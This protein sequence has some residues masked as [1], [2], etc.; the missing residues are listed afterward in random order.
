MLA[1]RWCAII[2][3]LAAGLTL[4]GCGAV[5]LAYNNAPDLTYW[6]LDGFL[7]LDSAQ[8]ARLRNDLNALQAWHRKEELP[9]VAEMLKNLQAAVSP[10]RGCRS[11]MPAIALP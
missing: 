6:W 2:C 4:T 5:R 9:A 10:A 7:D 3:L 8:S 11:G 1:R